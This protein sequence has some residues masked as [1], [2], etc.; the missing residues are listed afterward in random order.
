M[1]LHYEFA[2]VLDARDGLLAQLYVTGRMLL[3][4]DQGD[5]TD[6]V[7]PL[8]H[9]ANRVIDALWPYSSVSR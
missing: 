1:Q 6:L 8:H 3:R 5:Y 7:I 4:I 9:N 2:G